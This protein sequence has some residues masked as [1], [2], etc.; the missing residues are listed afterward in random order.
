MS[1]NISGNQPLSFKGGVNTGAPPS[2]LP[3]QPQLP[4]PIGKKMDQGMN[5]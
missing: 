3:S 1:G 2:Q 5:Q 4:L